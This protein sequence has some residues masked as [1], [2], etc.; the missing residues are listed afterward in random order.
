MD[1]DNIRTHVGFAILLILIISLIWFAWDYLA[2]RLNK[3]A[4]STI[5]GFQ[6]TSPTPF[7]NKLLELSVGPTAT[8]NIIEL[9]GKFKITGFKFSKS[10][11][12]SL[13]ADNK[14]YKVY[15]ANDRN[16]IK[17]ADNRSLILNSNGKPEFEV[18]TPYYDIGL[19][20]NDDGT[21]KYTGGCLLIEKAGLDF[22]PF[23]KVEVYGLAPYAL[24]KADYEKMPLVTTRQLY[25]EV[26]TTAGGKPEVLL[27]CK[28][29]VK[30]KDAN[31][32]IGWL[33]ITVSYQGIYSF[34]DIPR[35]IESFTTVADVDRVVV[36]YQN[37]LDGM[38][39]IYAVDGPYQLAFIE[40]KDTGSNSL[41]IYFDEPIIA[42]RVRLEGICD[43]CITGNLQKDEIPS[44]TNS[45]SPGKPPN[46]ADYR[47]PIKIANADVKNATLPIVK[48]YGTLAVA[49]DEVNFKLQRQKFDQRGIVIEG[50]KCPNV[51][52]M[53]NKQLQA[54]LIC[55]SL[56]Y[57]DRE[58]NKRVA[59]ETDKVYL[60]KLGDQ[61][62]EIK[63]L[64]A[65]ISDLIKRKNI[66]V[67]NS[68]GG[69]NIDELSTV[70]NKAESARKEAESYM[71]NRA[72][73][74]QGVNVK[75]NLDP[76][77]TG[78]AS[79]L[80]SRNNPL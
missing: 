77:F 12:G 5:E 33:D 78:I 42:S 24:S 61:E 11:N 41:R 59:Y 43:N 60:Q 53:M 6:N 18:G 31:Y 16:D 74:R 9:P 3:L 70:L 30:D 35:A 80:A 37:T 27:N 62:R 4:T 25:V 69:T 51:G 1:N 67:S 40:S 49:R 56:E 23:G 2:T 52:E 39:N 14:T 55:E 44:S 72:A 58:R 76:Q 57:K 47:D 29:P 50:E 20:E 71:A 54:Q 7:G 65:T 32:K 79:K 15:I 8:D 64:E 68:S 45:A 22:P 73:S 66:R 19:F 36:R 75:V 34:T 63:G 28:D 17:V 48:A 10:A 21:S 46:P 13:T 26:P 38:T